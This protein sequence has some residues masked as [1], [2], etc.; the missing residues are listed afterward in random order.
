[1]NEK[2]NLRPCRN[3]GSKFVELIGAEPGDTP[4][5]LCHGCGE[6]FDVSDEH[7][8][9]VTDIDRVVKAWNRR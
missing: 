9:L 2:P 7:G 8:K 4:W 5:I 6:V 1:M 3:C